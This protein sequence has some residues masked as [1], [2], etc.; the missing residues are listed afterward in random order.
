LLISGCGTSAGGSPVLTKSPIATSSV[1]PSATSSL[2]T[3]SF[4]P[5]A[6]VTL[7][8]PDLTL[9]LPPAWQRLSIADLRGRIEQSAVGSSPAVKAAYEDLLGQIDAG[10]VRSGAIGPS[11][12]E[13]WRGT[14]L[15]AVTH[16]ESIDAEIK[17]IRALQ[18]AFGNPPTSTQRTTVTLPIGEA[19][20]TM[21][22]ADP[23]PGTEGRAV[24]ARGVAYYID[25]GDGRIFWMTATGPQDSP[26]FEAMID[27]SMATLSRR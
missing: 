2:I 9:R 16:A 1:S 10:E 22:T 4:A 24:A 23:A 5:V 27:A 17:R 14:M 6:I 19:V 12:F 13:A 11:G 7:D 8:D 3:S 18:V 26:T 15:I 25:L 21:D 20:G